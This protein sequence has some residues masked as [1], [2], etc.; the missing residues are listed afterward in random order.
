[1]SPTRMASEHKWIYIGASVVLVVIA[2]IGLFTYTQQKATNEARR[3]AQELSDALVAKGF[4]RFDTDNI[5]LALGT[6]GGAVCT[7]PN[8]ALKRGLWRVQMANGAGG[9]GMRPIIADSRILEAGAEVIR[10]Y[11]P[12]KLAD[13][14]EKIDDLKTADLVND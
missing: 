2:V 7:D 5:A 10:V 13:Y 12:D 11:C 9:P 1:M 6:D 4:R 14:Q 3:K 8:S